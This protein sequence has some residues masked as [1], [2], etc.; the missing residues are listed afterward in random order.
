LDAFYRDGHGTMASLVQQL[1]HGAKA[2]LTSPEVMSDRT[3]LRIRHKHLLGTWPDLDDPVTFNEK[4]LWRILN[5]RSPLLPQVTDKVTVRRFVASRVGEDYFTR[6]YAVVERAAELD[7]RALPRSFVIKP[8]HGSGWTRIVRDK[9]TADPL[10]ILVAAQSWLRANYYRKGREWAYRN[11][12]PRLI[13]EG[14]LLEDGQIPRDYKLFCFHGEPLVIQVTSGRFTHHTRTLY[15]TAWRR[16]PFELLYPAG[17]DILRP[18]GLPE[19]LRVA[20][21]LSQ[22]FDFLRVDLYHIDG[23]VYFGELTCY[24]GNG[25][26]PFRPA[27]FDAELGAWWHLPAAR[28]TKEA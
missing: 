1:R 6:R 9:S 17:P 21:A 10:E 22:P 23:R 18:K 24:P 20:R 11:I 13:V 26:E 19:M 8:N 14:L 28:L 5:D 25:T 15:D 7:W 16:L 12:Q 4:V 2:A 27:G 3:Y